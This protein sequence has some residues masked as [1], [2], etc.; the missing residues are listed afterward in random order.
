MGYSG[1]FAG[2]AI[3][4][5]KYAIIG[6]L[7]IGL[8]FTSIMALFENSSYFVDHL[9]IFILRHVPFGV[10]FFM[11]QCGLLTQVVHNDII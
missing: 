6:R 10:R 7:L 5:R 4:P 11:R 2:Q 8:S 3:F 1:H 9:Q